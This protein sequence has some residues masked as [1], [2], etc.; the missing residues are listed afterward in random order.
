MR[1]VSG[2][3]PEGMQPWEPSLAITS[4]G[5]ITHTL[6][7]PNSPGLWYVMS[8]AVTPDGARARSWSVMR[9]EPGPWLQGPPA[10]SATVGEAATLWTTVHNSGPTVFSSGVRTVEEGSAKIVGA[11]SQPL[12]VPAGE[13]RRLS[14]RVISPQAGAGRVGFAF[15]PSSDTAGMWTATVRAAAGPRTDVTYTAGV[16]G[17]ERTVGVAVPSGLAAETLRLEIHA[18]VSMLPA[19]AAAAVSPPGNDVSSAAARLSGPASVASAYARL[20]AEVPESAALSAVERSMLLQ[21]IYS[22]QRPDGGWGGDPTPGSSSSV[23][24]TGEV[25]LALQRMNAYAPAGAQTVQPD[26]AAVNRALTYLSSEMARPADPVAGA[27]ALDE[28][29]FGLYVLAAYRPVAAEVVRPMV[30]YAGGRENGLTPDGQAWL[31]LAL[32]QSGNSADALAV[33]NHMLKHEPAA[34]DVT[35]SMLEAV[36]EAQRTLPTLAARP[37]DLPDYAAAASAFARALMEARQGA[38]W[39][40]PGMTAHALSALSRYA[41]TQ[42]DA[43]EGGLPALELGDRPVQTRSASGDT[44]TVSVVLTGNELHP[45]MNW[46]RLIAP[47]PD[48]TLYYSLALTA[49]R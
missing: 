34:A 44:A 9:V 37:A 20:N 23:R 35:P 18:S 42:G 25:L 47:A 2:A 1:R 7:A 43:P 49:T 19:L 31:A 16:T 21:Q 29:A 13:W 22:A 41:V 8:E 46:L 26:L 11:S 14:W 39:A 38:G 5:A 17:G 30:L 24:T 40:T 3:L 6:Q 48:R 4:T 15:M 27:A 45:G 28:R 12:E 32:W 36:L 10:Q 33:L